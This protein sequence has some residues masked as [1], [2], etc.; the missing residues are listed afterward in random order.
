MKI[1]MLFELVR[2][3]GKDYTVFPLAPLFADC[4][5]TS[6]GGDFL[7]ESES[8]TAQGKSRQEIF[9]FSYGGG[10]RNVTLPSSSLRA[11]TDQ[12]GSNI[13]SGMCKVSADC[14]DQRSLML[15][16]YECLLIMEHPGINFDSTR[17][18]QSR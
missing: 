15:G 5:T 9:S 3:T 17:S 10:P 16:L 18:H 1:Q 6:G 12:L 2:A 13:D 14:P 11:W 7:Q 8:T 4:V